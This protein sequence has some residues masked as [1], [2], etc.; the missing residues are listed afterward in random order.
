MAWRTFKRMISEK[1][2]GLATV[3]AD[4]PTNDDIQVKAEEIL[5]QADEKN[6]G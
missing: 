4:P 3:V 6:V 1:A 2:N 5:A